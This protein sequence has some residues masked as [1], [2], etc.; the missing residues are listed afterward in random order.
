[1]STLYVV[2]TPIGNLGDI[3]FRAVETL[4]AVSLVACEDTR[5]T[6]KLLTH[7][8]IRVKML[9]VRSANEKTAA[10]KVAAVLR[11]G[12]DVAYVSDAGTPALSDPGAALVRAVTDAGFEAVPIPGVSA[13]TSLLSVAGALD[14]TV[15]FE[16]FLSPKASRRKRRVGELMAGSAGFVVYESPFRIFKLLENIADFDNARYMC[17]GREMTKLHEEFI[18]GD[19]GTVCRKLAQ[20]GEPRGE[21]AVYV[22]AFTLGK[23]EK[24]AQ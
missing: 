5:R 2:A 10:D 24:P 6:L 18:R 22:S 14:K 1:M 21:F 4:K 23:A 17:V 11:E 20:A 19:A 13:F 16:G 8:D 9:S 3:T 7:F 15:V 12:Q